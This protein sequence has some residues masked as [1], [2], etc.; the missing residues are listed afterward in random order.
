MQKTR[1]DIDF[2]K[3]VAIICV[4]FY[5]LFDLL[6]ISYN[7]N[8]HLFDGGFLG[9]DIFLVISG[10]LITNSIFKSLKTDSFSLLDFYKK[11]LLRL[12]PP[13][14]VL[15][16]FCLFF[17]YFLL[18]PDVYKETAIES[19]NALIGTSN[20]RFA[21]SGGYFSLDNSDKVL[22]HT[23]YIALTVQFYL[24]FPILIGVFNRYFKG[25]S[26]F[27]VL[28]FTVFLIIASVLLSKD[29]KAY[30]LTQTR[31]FELF[32]GSSVFLF[33]DKICSFFR[34]NERFSQVVFYTAT[35]MIVYTVLTTDLSDAHWNP[36]TSVLTII[37]TSLIL[38]VNYEKSFII[39]TKFNLFGKI[40]YSIYLW[41]WPVFIFALKIGLNTSAIS[42]ISVLLLTLIVSNI[43]FFTLEKRKLP[44]TVIIVS[45]IFI[46][47]S[48]LYIKKVKG[49]NYL[50]SFMVETKLNF[51]PKSPKIDFSIDDQKVFVLGN[52]DKK[53][54]IFITGDSHTMQY[55]DFF[56][57][58]YQGSVYYSAYEATMSYGPVFNNINTVYLN[59]GK[60]KRQNFYKAYIHTLNKLEDNA[61]VIISNNYYLHYKPY[62]A[63][64][65]LKDSDESFDLFIKDMISDIDSQVKKHK[66]L[67]FNIV[68]QGIYTTFTIAKCLKTDLHDS[69]LRF[70]IKQDNCQETYD[71]IYERRLKINNAFKEYAK[72]NSNVFFIDRNEP[73]LK[74][75]NSKNSTYTTV[76]KNKAP[77]FRDNHHY[78]PIGGILIGQYIMN[79]LNKR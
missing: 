69:F 40:S 44:N 56:N 22:L 8:F 61:S 75:N 72:N 57:D 41:H 47:I 31:I 38:V 13:L 25:N 23:W 16:L 70:V 62:L 52:K 11:R 6:N 5:H 10:Y 76:D 65:K 53:P 48:Y 28:G 46:S 1:N 54:N 37:A 74:N 29:E 9:V 24:I 58:V 14:I 30:L 79:N 12:Y 71:F 34:I 77:L 33:Q 66:K 68:G 26:K 2:F 18:F 55:F 39:N 35:L 73:L 20:I 15:I 43:S 60:T 32:V 50:S 36:C 51:E 3:A 67:N 27:Y 21:N 78:T 49:E 17:G 42:C 64:K 19:V 7:L 63:Q 59:I 4:V 45:L